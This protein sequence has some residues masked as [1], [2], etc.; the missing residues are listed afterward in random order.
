MNADLEAINVMQMPTVL[1]QLAPTAVPAKKGSLG[2]DV[3]VQD[4]LTRRIW[5]LHDYETFNVL[6]FCPVIV[7][8]DMNAAVE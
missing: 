7:D 1:T 6:D 3:R 2:M 4:N 5:D 8:I